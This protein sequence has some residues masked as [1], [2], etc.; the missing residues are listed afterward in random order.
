MVTIRLQQKVTLKGKGELNWF[1]CRDIRQIELNTGSCH[2]LIMLIFGAIQIILR[3]VFAA[4]L[5]IASVADDAQIG[6]CWKPFRVNQIKR[7]IVQNVLHWFY[8]IKTTISKFVEFPLALE[9]HN[10]IVKSQVVGSKEASIGRPLP[11][12]VMVDCASGLN[13]KRISVFLCDSFLTF[14]CL[15]NQS[16]VSFRHAFVSKGRIISKKMQSVVNATSR[17]P[18][19]SSNQF[20]TLIIA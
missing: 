8:T 17:A 20:H 2:I 12:G 6:T 19:S 15:S 18:F 1:D 13:Q 9:K 11:L 7:E 5:N 3:G 14:A 16:F 4:F 10:N